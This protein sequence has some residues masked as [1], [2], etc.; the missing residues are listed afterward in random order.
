L[1]PAQEKPSIFTLVIIRSSA[2]S[3]LHGVK[4]TSN[5]NIF[6]LDSASTDTDLKTMHYDWSW[7]WKILKDN[8][9]SNPGSRDCLANSKKKL[10]ETEMVLVV[11]ISNE[12]DDVKDHSFFWLT[13]N[14]YPISVNILNSASAIIWNKTGMDRF[15]DCCKA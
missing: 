10:P 4:L 12:I 11:L 5:S 13:R 7:D 15:Q 6:Q 14:L 8:F 9:G 2:T 1:V 3:S